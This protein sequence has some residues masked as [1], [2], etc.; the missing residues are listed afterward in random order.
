[1]NNKY[2]LDDYGAAI[3][4]M[5]MVTKPFSVFYIPSNAEGSL[6]ITGVTWFH[7][8]YMLLFSQ[9]LNLNGCCPAPKVSDHR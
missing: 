7:E 8:M 6:E 5:Q 1:M 2:S 3:N 9:Y 4:G